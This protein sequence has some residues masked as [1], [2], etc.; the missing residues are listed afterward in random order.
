MSKIDVSAIESE[1]E[2][3][4]PKGSGGHLCSLQKLVAEHPEAEGVL[5]RAIGDMRY[6]TRRVAEV[7][8]ANGL[9]ISE[10]TVRKHRNNACT[11]CKE[12]SRV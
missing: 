6:G 7:L 2:S 4:P 8:T 9:T 11:T 12:A 1:L 10:T 5:R 3:L